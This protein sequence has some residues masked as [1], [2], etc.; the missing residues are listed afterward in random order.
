MNYSIHLVLK[1]VSY[2]TSC[3][4]LKIRILHMSKS[5]LL[6]INLYDKT[7]CDTLGDNKLI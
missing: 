1:T 3:L 6:T 7:N 2:H 4:H 5:L